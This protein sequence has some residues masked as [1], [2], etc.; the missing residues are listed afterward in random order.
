MLIQIAEEVMP[1][2]LERSNS[3]ERSGSIQ[4]KHLEEQDASYSRT[5]AYEL[6]SDIRD[7]QVEALRVSRHLILVVLISL[8]LL[9]LMVLCQVRYEKRSL[10]VQTCN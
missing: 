9:L 8:L 3:L 5:A 2:K 6:S 1:S 10:I 7:R 4:R